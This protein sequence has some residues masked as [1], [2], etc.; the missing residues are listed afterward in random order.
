MV[1]GGLRIR[2]QLILLRGPT[3]LRQGHRANAD[4]QRSRIRHLVHLELGGPGA[5]ALVYRVLLGRGDRDLIS[6]Q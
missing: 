3:R 1:A 5:R 2:R 4:L 6:Q